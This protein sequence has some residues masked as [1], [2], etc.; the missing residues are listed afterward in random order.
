MRRLLVAVVIVVLS[1]TLWAALTHTEVGEAYRNGMSVYQATG[2][3]D[4]ALKA[5]YDA[6]R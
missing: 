6:A 1:V 4:E 3:R 2:S 5:W